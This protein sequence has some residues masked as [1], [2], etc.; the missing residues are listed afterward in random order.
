MYINIFYY[1]H[2]VQYTEKHST[3]N[4]HSV[5]TTVPQSVTTAETSTTI[6]TLSTTSTETAMG[7]LSSCSYLSW[8]ITV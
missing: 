1:V 6:T 2:T 7:E 8:S 3:V 5:N 4:V